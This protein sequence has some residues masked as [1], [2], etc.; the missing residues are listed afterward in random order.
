M[1]DQIVTEKDRETIIEMREQGFS[2]AAIAQTFGV[3]RQRI[4]Q[5]VMRPPP[6]G[7]PGRPRKI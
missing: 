2:Y 7:K 5:L 1:A 6:Y 4:H 3:S